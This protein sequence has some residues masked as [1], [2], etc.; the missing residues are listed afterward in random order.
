MLYLLGRIRDL[1]NI[2]NFKFPASM[3]L[4]LVAPPPGMGNIMN[5]SFTFCFDTDVAT[6]LPLYG[7]IIIHI[8]VHVSKMPAN[9]RLFLKAFLVVFEIKKSRK[10]QTPK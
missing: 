3:G 5:R 4:P 1:P 9:L 10:E 2:R 7:T 8:H 6:S